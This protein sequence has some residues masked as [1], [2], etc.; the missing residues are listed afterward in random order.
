MKREFEFTES[1]PLIRCIEQNKDKL[2]GKKISHYY[3]DSCTGIGASPAV[4][5]I[6]DMAIVI[7]YYWYSCMD[8]VVVD[9][10]S[11]LADTTLHFLYKDIPESRNV[12]YTEYRYDDMVDFVGK[13]IKRITVERFSD[14][15]ETCQFLGGVRPKGGDYFKTI[16]IKMSNGK[17]FY[18]CGEDA[19]FDGYMNVWE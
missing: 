11:F 16:T 3:R 13:R 8:V 4:F 10:E 2:I 15:H 12:Y 5:I 14:A 18:I 9:K 1:A 17:E 19:L 6:D 7:F